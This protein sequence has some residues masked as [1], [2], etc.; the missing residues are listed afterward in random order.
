MRTLLLAGADSAAH[1]QQR[2]AALGGRTTSTA[3]RA[4]LRVG[5]PP[6]LCPLAALPPPV[7]LRIVGLA[8]H[9]LSAWLPWE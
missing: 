8:A 6:A 5:G 2:V 3:Q 4:H 7:L 1:Q 9:P